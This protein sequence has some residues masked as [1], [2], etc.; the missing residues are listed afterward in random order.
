MPSLLRGIFYMIK[1]KI[2]GVYMFN[3]TRYDLETRFVHFVHEKTNSDWKGDDLFS[4]VEIP[5]LYGSDT[6]NKIYINMEMNEDLSLSGRFERIKTDPTLQLAVMYDYDAI[7]IGTIFEVLDVKNIYI[8]YFVYNS[9][10]DALFYVHR[11]LVRE[12]PFDFDSIIELSKTRRLFSNAL[13]RRFSAIIDYGTV[14]MMEDF[15]NKA[16][17]TE[18]WNFMIRTLKDTLKYDVSEI[19]DLE[20][21]M[22]IMRILGVDAEDTNE[23]KL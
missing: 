4:H 22:Y 20:M 5:E 23:L 2:G 10:N 7:E 1:I 12:E 17:G 14:E 18:S 16:S 3:Q 13:R 6:H 19:N 15:Y 9:S 11:D 8:R 21:R